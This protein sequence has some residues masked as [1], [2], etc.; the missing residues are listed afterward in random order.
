M[1]Q[2]VLILFICPYMFDLSRE[3]AM[4]NKSRKYCQHLQKYLD[5]FEKR[6]G[7]SHGEDF[8]FSPNVSR[9]WKQQSQ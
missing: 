5:F 9:M 3:V 8:K 6:F 2:M 4:S 1:G 7:Q